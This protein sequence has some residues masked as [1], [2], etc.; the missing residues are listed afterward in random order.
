MSAFINNKNN[1][2][3]KFILDYHVHGNGNKREELTEFLLLSAS[4]H[5]VF[6]PCNDK[7]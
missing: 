2:L 7:E 5:T 3:K 4:M 6:S 1:I